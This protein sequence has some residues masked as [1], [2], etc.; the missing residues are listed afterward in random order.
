MAFWAARRLA[1]LIRQISFDLMVLNVVS[2][3]ALSWQLSFSADRWNNAVRLQELLVFG[4]AILAAAIGMV[5]HAG[6]WPAQGNSPLQGSIAKSL[7]IQILTD[8]STI[9]PEKTSKTMARYSQP[10]VVHT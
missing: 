10:S 4:G 2:I 1:Q 5:G 9:R 8:K 6:L 3:M 7:F